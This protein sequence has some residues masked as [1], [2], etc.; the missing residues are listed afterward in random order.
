MLIHSD[1]HHLAMNISMQ[2][3]VGI[4]LEWYQG[5]KKTSVIYVSG[6]IFG[7]LGAFVFQSGT[8]VIGAS[9][10]TYALLWSHFAD[11]FMVSIK[12]HNSTSY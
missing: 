11:C 2:F 10:G 7:T 4:P 9:A 1:V 8:K 3:V 12:L 5:S 6:I